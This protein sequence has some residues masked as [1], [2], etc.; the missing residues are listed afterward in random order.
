[1]DNIFTMFPTIGCIAV[2]CFLACQAVKLT[3][4]PTKFVPVISAV[5][6]AILGVVGQVLGI[7]ELAN[8]SILDAIATGICSGLVASGGYSLAKNLAGD[9]PSNELSSKEQKDLEFAEAVDAAIAAK[10][11]ATSEEPVG[12]TPEATETTETKEG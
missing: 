4:L 7:A 11:N 10:E 1:M 8:V 3:S 12:E 2:I 5:V 6:G 9:Y